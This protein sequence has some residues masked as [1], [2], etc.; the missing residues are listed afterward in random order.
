MQDSVKNQ[1][2]PSVLDQYSDF[3]DY[4]SKE[5]SHHEYAN[6]HTTLGYDSRV[7]ISRL[8][9]RKSSWSFNE[10]AETIKLLENPVL[11]S[12]LIKHFKVRHELTKNEPMVI[13]SFAI[14][15]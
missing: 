11:P 14:G 8:L 7:R 2:K 15:G 1:I 12:K 6:L 10:M 5:L 13:D 9:N 4:L 3:D